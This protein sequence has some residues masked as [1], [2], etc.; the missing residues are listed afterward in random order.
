[1][2]EST[3]RSEIE[4]VVADRTGREC[5]FTPSGRVALWLALRTWL[6]PCDQLLMSPL[7]CDVVLFTVL[8]AGLRPVMAPVSLEDGNIDP[9]AIPAALWSQIDGVLTTNLY[10]LP[11]RLPELRSRCVGLSIPLIE[12]AAQAL[13]SEV[14][15]RPVG[16]FGD[17]AAFSLSKHAR[18]P[19]GGALVFADRA[20]RP[21]LERLLAAVT[22][23]RTRARLAMD[24][25]RPPLEA[26]IRRLHLL[27]LARST[28]RGMGLDRRA[29][30]N[31]MP[32]RHTAL[33]RALTATPDVTALE[34]WVRCD[35]PGYRMAVPPV[36]LRCILERLR[37]LEADRARRAS[38]VD[39]LR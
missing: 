5:L 38:G 17:A 15:S 1:M 14:A 10:G 19:A 20:R 33:R 34:A 36:L 24:L 6:R 18:A 37:Q 26:G 25:Y 7:T 23:P 35:L 9:H 4:A 28:A 21:D 30:S 32:L 16:T 31:R 13:E 22:A 29:T 27:R 12:D 2:T 8:A 39:R 11:D 3:L